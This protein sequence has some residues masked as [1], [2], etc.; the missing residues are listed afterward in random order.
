MKSNIDNLSLK[1]LGYQ[2]LRGVLYLHS[3]Q[4]C[5]RDI[6][7]RNFFL[8][9]HRLV[10]GDFGSAKVMKKHKN[11]SVAYICSRHYR[12]PELILGYKSYNKSIDIWSAACVIAEIALGKPLFAG[13][14][15]LDQLVKILRVLGTPNWRKL[16]FMFDHT[17]KLPFFTGKGLEKVLFQNSSKHF[18]D[19]LKSM[20]IINPLHR[21]T[22]G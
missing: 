7:P 15:S 22:A 18:T 11:S 3:H 20:L 19:L 10:L 17:P 2:I 8:K 13:T 12:A 6:K 1:I 9:N 21:L 16:S 5:H 4:I 14:S